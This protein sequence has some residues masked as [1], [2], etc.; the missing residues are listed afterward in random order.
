MISRIFGPCVNKIFT[1]WHP[2]NLYLTV[3]HC[4]KNGMLVDRKMI[5]LEYIFRHGDTLDNQLIV[6]I[7]V[8]G[9][10]ESNDEYTKLV[11]QGFNL[12]TCNMTT[13]D[14]RY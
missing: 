13:D 8:S 11:G 6:Y 3:G 10:F 1:S 4:F 9:F 7:H 2:A 12:F 5:L 14:F